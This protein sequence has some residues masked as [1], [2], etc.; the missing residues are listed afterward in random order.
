[1]QGGQWRC[2]GETRV[3]IVHRHIAGVQIWVGGIAVFVIHVD[4]SFAVSLWRISPWCSEKRYQAVKNSSY[5]EKANTSGFQL[6]SLWGT[7]GPGKICKR[8]KKTN[9]IISWRL[10]LN[11]LHI[12][13]FPLPLS[14]VFSEKPRFWRHSHRGVARLK[15]KAR[16]E[17]T[18]AAIPSASSAFQERGSGKE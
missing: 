3:H 15:M 13:M 18:R 4:V 17:K 7:L 1:M 10:A 16:R 9:K 6:D 2:S 8:K 11:P 5:S 12:S 14:T